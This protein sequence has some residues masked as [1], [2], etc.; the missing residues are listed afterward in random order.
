MGYNKPNLTK[1]AESNV[2]KSVQWLLSKPQD[3]L[4]DNTGTE[5][6][7]VFYKQSILNR[8]GKVSGKQQSVID[9]IAQL[10]LCDSDCRLD[11]EKILGICRRDD[12][13]YNNN[14]DGTLTRAQSNRVEERKAIEIWKKHKNKSIKGVGK[15][16]DYQV[17][18]KD[19]RAD[20][21]GKID[22]LSYDEKDNILRILEL[23][24]YGNDSDSLLRT[25]L[26]AETYKRVLI[27]T[28]RKKKTDSCYGDGVSKL[29]VEYGI[30]S[31]ARVVACP[32]LLIKE[33]LLKYRWQFDKDKGNIGFRAYEEFCNPKD[34]EHVFKL[35]NS[36]QQEIIIIY[37]CSP[38]CF[39][40][41]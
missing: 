11:F 26:E 22:L 36:L 14:H 6:I 9:Y 16:L 3:L 5:N 37:E 19:A 31:D 1:N 8:K 30:P 33:E 24:I 25:I 39:A 17:P 32:L 23:K 13:P 10:L 27:N 20:K 29:K 41:N 21:S 12:K 18:L 15:I 38:D 2:K 34:F 40:K 28:H 7:D 35:A 4:S